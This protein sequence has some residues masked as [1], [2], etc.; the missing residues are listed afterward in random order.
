MAPDPKLF[1]KS[2]T[3]T[4]SLQ[5][6]F[7]GPG[8]VNAAG[9][10]SLVAGAQD[11]GRQP[12]DDVPNANSKEGDGEGEPNYK[13]ELVCRTFVGDDGARPLAPG[14]IFYESP[15]IWVVAPDGSDIPIAGVVNQVMVHVW[16]L[17]LA[18]A[19]GVNVE[20]YWCNPSVGVN[21]ANATQIGTTQQT[22]LN[23]GEHK[24]LSFD[25]TPEIVNNGH[26]CL[27]VQVYDPIADNLAAP[28]NPIQDSHVAQHNIN[29]IR[30]PAGHQIHLNFRAPNLSQSIG[31]ALIRVEKVTGDALQTMAKGLGLGFLPEFGGA[32]A[33]ISKIDIRNA[34][35]MLDLVQHPV[36]AV[37]REALEPMPQ[38]LP[39]ALMQ[40]ALAT[41]SSSE[42][43]DKK[44]APERHNVKSPPINRT[45]EK[46]PATSAVGPEPIEIPPGK[47]L[48]LTLAISL[49]EN[50]RRGAYTAF[51][52]IETARER[53]T[54]GITYLVQVS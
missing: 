17:G 10:L 48:N 49:P 37:F 22:T 42:N 19:S 23:A 51:R 9:F 4:K 32:Q 52:V 36:A 30:V 5:S 27:V 43:R 24:I 12:R 26:E 54:G 41:L 13:P 38:R 53:I 15:D 2:A 28:F 47:E 14:I 44:P 33:V 16:N 1:N 8:R 46:M 34:Q 21:L 11:G 35:P 50:A 25:W 40:S 6:R 3:L 29:Q 39:R 20:L 18:P 31:T 45:P 7:P